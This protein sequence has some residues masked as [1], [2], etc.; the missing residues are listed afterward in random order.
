LNFWVLSGLS[1]NQ[2]I[3]SIVRR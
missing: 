3:E 2:L 1:F